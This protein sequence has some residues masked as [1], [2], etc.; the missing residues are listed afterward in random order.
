MFCTGPVGGDGCRRRW[1]PVQGCMGC[2]MKMHRYRFIVPQVV[3]SSGQ[4]FSFYLDFFNIFSEI[5]SRV[6][7]GGESKLCS[8]VLEPTIIYIALNIL[9]SKVI[10]TNWFVNILQ[11]IPAT[12]TNINVH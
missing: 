8:L 2:K 6:F 4:L 12:D 10:K 11:L 3:R 9:L 1:H 7:S 5:I